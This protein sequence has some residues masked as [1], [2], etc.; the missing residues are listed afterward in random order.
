MEDFATGQL[1]P[2]YRLDLDPYNQKEN[3]FK[4]KFHKRMF[5]QLH[6]VVELKIGGLSFE[7]NLD[8]QMSKL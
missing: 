2:P 4:T 8:I 7:Q 5:A 6:V 1:L 3:A